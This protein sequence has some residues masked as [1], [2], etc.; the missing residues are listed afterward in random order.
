[1]SALRLSDAERAAVASGAAAAALQLAE[2]FTFP[3]RDRAEWDRLRCELR[4]GFLAV[5]AG[6]FQPAS[7][8]GEQPQPE[9]ETTP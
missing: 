1:M 2:N 6:T 5:V 4:D 8:S 3:L 9:T 7:P